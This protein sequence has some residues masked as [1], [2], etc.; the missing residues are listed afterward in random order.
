MEKRFTDKFDLDE[1]KG[2]LHK[3]TLASY[4]NGGDVCAKE[5]FASIVFSAKDYKPHV[6][7]SVT[8]NGVTQHFGTNT[9]K[10]IDFYNSL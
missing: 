10:A 2:Y 6:I 8:C 7:L 3:M 1:M 9:K 4:C 5:L